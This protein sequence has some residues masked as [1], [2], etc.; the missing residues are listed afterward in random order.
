M[1]ITSYLL[2]KK[3]GG[4]SANLQEK[5]VTITT[6]KTTNITPDEGYD[7]LSKAVVTTNVPANIDLNDYFTSTITSGTNSKPGYMISVIGMKPPTTVTGTSLSYAYSSFQGE[8]LDLSQLDTSGVTN[9]TSIF[10]SS[11]LKTINVTGWNTISAT[12]M[13]SMFY[14]C[15][16]LTSITGLGSFNT[17]NVTNFAAMF[18][19]CKALKSIDI[20]NFDFGAATNI[21]NMFDY[22]DNL[23]TISFGS[24]LG[25]AYPA[26]ASTGLGTATTLTFSRCTK[27]TAQSVIN[28]VNNLYDISN[29]TSTPQW[30]TFHNNAYNRLTEQEQQALVATATAKG[31]EVRH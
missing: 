1:D 17:S 27:L 2:G 10:D 28:I 4:G 3:S 6:N 16:S 18:R 9:M 7:G 24:N 26:D 31:W 25:K 12:A 11:K 15:Q 13:S 23:E 22:C 21:N 5:S 8:T 29:I 14:Q 20:S 19:Y 30:V